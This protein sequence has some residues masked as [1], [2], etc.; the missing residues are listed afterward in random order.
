MPLL[1]ATKVLEDTLDKS[2]KPSEEWN[3]S[4][5][6]L[7]HIRNKKKSYMTDFLV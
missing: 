7:Q 6:K 5:H 2:F 1:N 4:T 3:I